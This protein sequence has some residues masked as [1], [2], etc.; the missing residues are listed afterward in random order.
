MHASMSD[1]LMESMS[2][3][4]KNGHDQVQRDRYYG[5]KNIPEMERWNI[6]DGCTSQF[7]TKAP[8][9]MRSIQSKEDPRIHTSVNTP[10]KFGQQID[11]TYL[12]HMQMCAAEYGRTDLIAAPQPVDGDRTII[13]DIDDFY[14]FHGHKND[15]DTQVALDNEVRETRLHP[16]ELP[17]FNL[18]EAKRDTVKRRELA[19]AFSS[20]TPPNAI[21][22]DLC[23]IKSNMSENRRNSLQNYNPAAPPVNVPG[24]ADDPVNLDKCG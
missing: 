21:L 14:H 24:G 5:K 12:E 1:A 20:G 2:E 23:Q 13:K 9:G 10:E 17:P 6:Q 7:A 19:D 11:R 22:G 18:F 16:L 15:D 8:K 4:I 3:P